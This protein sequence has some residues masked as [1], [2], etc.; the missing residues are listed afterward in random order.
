VSTRA[1]GT[2]IRGLITATLLVLLIYHLDLKALSSTLSS[3]RLWILIPAFFVQLGIM[4]IAARR[5]QI[6]LTN[7]GI[8][9]RYRYLL[10]LFW[11]GSFFNQFLPSTIGGDMVRTYYLAKEKNVSMATTLTASLLERS[12]GL[13]ALLLIGFAA[14]WIGEV[15][16]EGVPVLLVYLVL[17]LIYILA[18]LVLFNPHQHR[19]ISRV[20]HRF[21]LD[22]LNAKFEMVY[23]GL[24]TL[25][26]NVKALVLALA[27][28]LCMQF[29]AV[30]IVSI[31]SR[32]LHLEIP[33]SV[34]LVFVPL[35]NLSIMVPL[36]INGFGLRESIYLLLFSQTGLPEETAV[37]LSLVSVSVVMA[38]ALPGGV[39]YVLYKRKGRS[40]IES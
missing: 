21:H 39:L 34:F 20:L 15:S 12:G 26:R 33:F 32:A 9:H 7:F 30:V 23:A 22:R 6:I 24:H 5:W 25:S 1:S 27:L 16:I 4:L 35:I 38:S 10:R 17:G 29:M 11:I 36:T 18:N 40:S 13:G 8:T 2:L 14:T 37:A 19:L 31:C 28:S 3:I